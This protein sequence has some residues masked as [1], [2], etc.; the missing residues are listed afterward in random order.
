MKN[1][2]A[3]TLLEVMVALV[4]ISVTMGAIITSAGSSAAV[5][6]RLKEKT[7]A[8]WVAQNQIALYRAKNIWSTSLSSQNGK[9]Q[10][11]DVDWHW[12]MKINKTDDPLLHKIEVDVYLVD[13][14]VI[15][16][17]TGFVAK[18]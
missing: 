12:L 2:K 6:S 4:V 7:V 16:S 8:N 13:D 9:A 11:L 15:S 10:M 5:A 17:A 18:L 3:F 14:D 1:F